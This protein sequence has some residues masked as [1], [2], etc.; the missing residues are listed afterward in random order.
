MEVKKR[1]LI[2][3]IDLAIEMVKRGIPVILGEYYEA[4]ELLDLG[5]TESYFLANALNILH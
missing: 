5:I 2:S 4:K 1:E 3:R